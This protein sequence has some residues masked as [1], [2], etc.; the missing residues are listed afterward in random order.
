MHLNWFKAATQ[1][2]AKQTSYAAGSAQY[3]N[4][5]SEVR[6]DNC[7][8]FK[9]KVWMIVPAVGEV[10]NASQQQWQSP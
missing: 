4:L 10:L 2:K 9:S 3:H 6:D 1:C 5:P 8:H 7:T